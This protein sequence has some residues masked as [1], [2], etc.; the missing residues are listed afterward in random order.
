SP[1][2]IG[3]DKLY[4]LPV[5]KLAL[6]NFVSKLLQVRP[7]RTLTRSSAS[8]AGAATSILNS[9]LPLILPLLTLTNRKVLDASASTSIQ[10]FG[11]SCAGCAATLPPTLTPIVSRR[12]GPL[13]PP[14]PMVPAIPALTAAAS[15]WNAKNPW[16]SPGPVL[17]TSLPT[18][19]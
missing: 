3:L 9:V 10:T 14:T 2:A 6:A 12:N 5:A 17:S 13:S 16:A 19:I 7:N 18:A 15:N 11:S 4:G 1:T 8:P